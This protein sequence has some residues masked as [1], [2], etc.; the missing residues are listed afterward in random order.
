M[1]SIKAIQEVIQKT[2][3]TLR[4]STVVYLLQVSSQTI[5]F[6]IQHN[7]N[8]DFRSLF[9]VAC[10]ELHKDPNAA[11]GFRCEMLDT[12]RLSFEEAI[13]FTFL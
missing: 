10:M 1:S 12:E 2:M 9:F 3:K 8:F 6:I 13:P 5:R 11:D 7:L 4:Q